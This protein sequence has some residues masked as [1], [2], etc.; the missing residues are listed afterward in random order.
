MFHTMRTYPQKMFDIGVLINWT[1]SHRGLQVCNLSRIDL[2]KVKWL[3][4]RFS[5]PL[6]LHSSSQKL[7]VD[8]GQWFI[9]RSPELHECWRGVEMA[10]PE[11][12]YNHLSTRLCCSENRGTTFFIFSTSEQFPF[13]IFLLHLN[14]NYVDLFF[15]PVWSLLSRIFFIY[16]HF[17]WLL[18]AFPITAAAPCNC[19]W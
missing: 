11:M 6:F 4:P 17:C 10:D 16:C 18:P 1:L 19:F 2:V 14:S 3:S 7:T 12:Y 15:V 13:Y 8:C 5:Q 9:Y